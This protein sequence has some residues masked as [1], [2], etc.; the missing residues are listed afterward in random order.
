LA[1]NIPL[2]LKYK[3]RQV[4]ANNEAFRRGALSSAYGSLATLQAMTGDFSAAVNSI[5]EAESYEPNPLNIPN[6]T[7]RIATRLAW[8]RYYMDTGRGAVEESRGDLAAAERYY[9]SALK[10]AE[11]KGFDIAYWWR[12]SPALLALPRNLMRQGRLSEAEALIRD[13]LRKRL[14]GQ[15]WGNRTAFGAHIAAAAL[16]TLS[17]ITY[18]AG[19]HQDAIRLA[20][21]TANYYRTICAPPETLNLAMA[22]NVIGQAMAAEGR[23]SDAVSQYELIEKGLKND[24]GSFER[25][26]RGNLSWALALIRSGQIPTALDHLRA[27]LRKANLQFGQSHYKTAEI[28]AFIAIA[29]LAKGNLKASHDFF[30]KS[31][32]ILLSRR[33]ENS[34][35]DVTATAGDRRLKIVIENYIDLLFRLRNNQIASKPGLGFISETFRLAQIGRSQQV[36]R[37]L[38]ASSARVQLRNPTLADL[39]RREQDAQRRIRVLYGTL[40][41]LISADT[42]KERQ[43]QIVRKTIETLRDARRALTAEIESK[44]PDYANLINPKPGTIEEAQRF[45]KDGEA[46]ITTYVAEKATYVWAVPKSGQAAFARVPL[47]KPKIQTIV[48]NLRRALDPKV[49]TLGDI[50]DFDVAASHRLYRALLGPV[51]PGWKKARSLVI[52]AHDALGQLPFSVLVTENIQTGPEKE[53]LFSNYR[54]VPFL[55]HRHAVTVLP[56]V[57]A[58]NTLRS[59]PPASPARRSF[60]GFGDPL[61]SA[62]QAR[63]TQIA[64]NSADTVA[65]R[66]LIQV[67]GL[68][69]R[70]RAAPKLDGVASADLAKLP[71]LMDTADEVNG[72]ALAMNAD[73]T[74]D[75]F[76][77]KRAN[78]E[79]V[80]SMSLSDYKV[81]AF[82]T[83]GLVPGDLDGLTQPALAL[84]SPIVTGGNNDGLLTMGEILTLKLDAD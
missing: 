36:S 22:R 76:T 35:E 62:D 78:E 68:P 60:A 29:H 28:G 44:F 38:S 25:L 6:I 2:A 27:A 39:A 42:G 81:L 32:P 16:G 57:S 56:S 48:R 54:D 40:G 37:A 49:A 15:D 83:H 74:R 43:I 45:L 65:A 18:E 61:F 24:P 71:R 51:E 73:L 84:S 31:V 30:S 55:V 70:L 7:H 33:R 1:G 72:I 19:R 77:Q 52:V 47:G 64:D 82:A 5:S 21:A 26:F 23:W 41:K 46:L 75:V 67:R 34:G 69:V 66:G 4:Q 58:L 17:E 9:R 14:D 3:Q 20:Q 79:R 8:N 10:A 53:P 59:L 50:P 12:L 11:S 63:A 80:K 13:I